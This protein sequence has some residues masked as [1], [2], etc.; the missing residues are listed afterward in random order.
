MKLLGLEDW[1]WTIGGTLA[2]VCHALL[3]LGGA[4]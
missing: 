3:T 4:L 1:V 2:L